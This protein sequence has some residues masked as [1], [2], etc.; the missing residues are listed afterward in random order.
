[1][2]ELFRKYKIPLLAVCLILT[3]LLLYSANL[4]HRDKTT[5]VQKMVLQ[6]TA[7]LQKSIDSVSDTVDGWWRHYL[8]LVNVEQEDERL[9]VANRRLQAEL[10]SLQEVRLTN[11]RLRRLLDFKKRVDIPALPARV[12]GEDASS[13]FRTVVLDKGSRDGLREGMP[14][15]AAK[16]VVGRVVKVAPDASRVLLITDGSSA[17]AALVQRNRTRGVCRGQG[18]SLSL[19]FA[20]R[21]KDVAVG[22]RVITSGTGG[23]FPKGLAIGQVTDVSK[24]SF[25]LFQTI[26]LDPA[27]DFS[28][29]EEVLV[30]LK[31]KP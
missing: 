23:I 6:L 20:L 26:K 5:L 18:D 14:V 24:E 29:L 28:R 11:D 31:E 21:Q 13:W 15:V 8:W 30:L 9:R 10:D 12:I 4:R 19:Q 3:A 22:D 2:L 1:M 17:V 16:G 25:G 7:P 27:V